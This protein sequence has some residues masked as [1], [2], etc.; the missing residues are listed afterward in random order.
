MGPSEQREVDVGVFPPTTFIKVRG[1]K[2][3]VSLLFSIL[4]KLLG[5]QILSLHL[6]CICVIK[7][8][9]SFTASLFPIFRTGMQGGIFNLST[10][11]SHI[12][13]VHY[14]GQV[15]LLSLGK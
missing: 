13:Y 5:H 10:S 4:S 12:S 3:S 9:L 8:G 15:N 1:E 11:W 14:R 2:A 6:L 7:S